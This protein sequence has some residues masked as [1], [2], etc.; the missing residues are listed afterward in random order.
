MESPK[1][2]FSM[3]AILLLVN[4]CTKEKSSPLE[5]TWKMV[6]GTYTDLQSNQKIE[7]DESERFCIKI[8]SGNHFAV[9]EMFKDNPDSLFFAAVGTYE[10]SG[11]RYIETYSAS[12]VGYQVGTS[13]EFS[14]T[15]DSNNW[16]IT[17]SQEDMDLREIWVKVEQ[18]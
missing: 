1:H 17:R 12:N 4:G 14:F 13:R 5:G 7:T 18:R 9:V 10:V 11:N 15:L 6:S 2:L 8:M 3:L 16:T